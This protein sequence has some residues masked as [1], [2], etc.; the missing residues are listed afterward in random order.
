MD[1]MYMHEK[2]ASAVDALMLP[3]GRG[4]SASIAAAFH[5]IHL[6][7]MGE[8]VTTIEDDNARH[9]LNIVEKFMDTSGLEDPNGK[10]LHTVK[11][12]AMNDEQKLEFSKA[13]RELENI[14]D[15]L[16]EEKLRG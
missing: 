13:V 10:G 8:D 14:F 5:E 3:H 6:G 11:A 4:E 1:P 7:L 15:R 12:E 16:S 2:L 9:Y